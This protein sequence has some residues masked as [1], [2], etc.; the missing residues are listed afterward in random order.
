VE[1][2]AELPLVILVADV[3]HPLDPRDG[4]RVGP[5][6]VHAWRGRP[7]GPEDALFAASPELTRAYL[8][9]I[10]DYEARG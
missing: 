1:L 9:T 3:A 8:N 2:I 10:D 5:L 6:R 4:Y 7:T